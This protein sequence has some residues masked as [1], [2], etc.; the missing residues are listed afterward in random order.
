MPDLNR[1]GL[2]VTEYAACAVNTGAN[3]PPSRVRHRPSTANVRIK[4]L[5]AA[6]I[7]ANYLPCGRHSVVAISEWIVVVAIM[8]WIFHRSQVRPRIAV[9][10]EGYRSG[11]GVRSSRSY[12]TMVA[13][14]G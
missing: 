10:S 4:I 12:H 1:T 11:S 5:A 7:S 14:S 3:A 8:E 13:S 2:H 9:A 6:K